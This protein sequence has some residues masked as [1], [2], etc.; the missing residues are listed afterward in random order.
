[1]YATLVNGAFAVHDGVPTLADMQAVIDGY[2]EQAL[3]VPSKE[4]PMISL[5]VYVNDEGFLEGLPVYVAR[6][7]DGQPLAGNAVIVATDRVTGDT[8]AATKTELD[9]AMSWLVP[10]WPR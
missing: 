8:V 6:A 10:A 3:A 5:D 7:T 1:V 2:I 9:D 4:R